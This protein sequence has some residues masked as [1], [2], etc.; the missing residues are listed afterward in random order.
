[1]DYGLILIIG[2]FKIIRKLF[3]INFNPSIALD[4]LRIGSY[5][6]LSNL[7]LFYKTTESWVLAAYQ[8]TSYFGIF[9]HA[10]IYPIILV[11]YYNPHNKPHGQQL[12]KRQN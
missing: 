12:E 1:M 8:G 2:Y 6:S 9:T 5:L 7:E 4:A 11:I 10:Q 3:I